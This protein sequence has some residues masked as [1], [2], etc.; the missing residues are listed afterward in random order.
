MQEIIKQV[1]DEYQWKYLESNG[2]YKIDVEGE[3]SSWASFLRVENEDSFS[4]YSVLPVKAEAE[5]IQ[6]VSELLLR[7][8]YVIRVGSFEINLNTDENSQYGQIMFKTYGIVSEDIVKNTPDAAKE[9][10][11]RTVAF[12][13]LSMDYYS[14]ILLKA[15]YSDEINFDEIF[16]NNERGEQI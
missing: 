1:L 6:A 8:N 9:I 10:V 4:Y 15:I 14:K 3:N 2:V 16:N 13:M 11:R 12:N 7:L 5:K